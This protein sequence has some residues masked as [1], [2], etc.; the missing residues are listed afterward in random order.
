MTFG[1]IKSGLSPLM[2][3]IKLTDNAS[4]FMDL[5]SIMILF[6]NNSDLVGK[7]VINTYFCIQ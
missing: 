1:P 5:I 6:L 3:D 2:D 7:I 4:V